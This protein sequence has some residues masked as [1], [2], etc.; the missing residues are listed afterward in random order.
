M[1]TQIPLSSCIDGPINPKLWESLGMDHY[2]RNYPGGQNMTLE[3]YTRHVH[4][5]NF[6]CGIG[7]HCLA[8][9][10]CAPVAKL[11]WLVLYSVQQWNFYM[12][13]LYEAVQ[14]AITMVREAAASAVSDFTPNEP[15]KWMGLTITTGVL[16][17]IVLATAGAM[18][19]F[20][21]SPAAAISEEAIVA[22]LEGEV[23]AATA[24]PLEG[25]VAASAPPL[26]AQ[27]TAAAAG[28]AAS[29]PV[30][31]RRHHKETL[32]TD[33]F[34]A[35]AKL[36]NDIG[37]LQFKLNKVISINMNSVL[38]SPIS[39]DLGVYNVVKNATYLIP[40]PGK[41][42]LQQSAKKLA[43]LTMISELFKSLKMFAVVGTGPCNGDGPNGALSG[44]DVISYCSDEGVLMNIVRADGDKMNQQIPNGNL[45]SRKY[46]FETKY[47]ISTAWSCQEKCQA[48]LKS[49]G[50]SPHPNN[51]TTIAE[52]SNRINSDCAFTLPVCDTRLPEI[53]KR[54]NNH[55]DVVIACREAGNLDI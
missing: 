40:N 11:D 32:S 46:G 5:A 21:I 55:D 45:L 17:A 43:Q 23:A 50:S 42:E 38:T 30:L 8:G 27:S 25:E 54:I 28:T 16:V 37:R 41:S 31:R 20:P 10:P 36:D 51:S 53:R 22:P 34:A 1:S 2:L 44:N 52:T 3:Q 19:L 48:R 39:S 14:G 9:Q 49:T 12:N 18:M 33:K 29:A 47:L 6:I 24:A 13:S 35:Y 15:V 7:R 4:A 26:Q